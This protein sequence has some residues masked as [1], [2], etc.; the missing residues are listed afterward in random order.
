MAVQVHVLPG[1]DVVVRVGLGALVVPRAVADAVGVDRLTGAL[2]GLEGSRFTTAAAQV[3]GADGRVAAVSPGES[4]W[5]VVAPEGWQVRTRYADRRSVNDGPVHAV[6]HDPSA[7]A[8][9]GPGVDLLDGWAVEEGA[10]GLPALGEGDHTAGGGL[11]LVVVAEPVDED[12]VLVRGIRCDCGA[13]HPP[14]TLACASCG[15]DL[16]DGPLVQGVRPSL[17]ELHVDDGRTFPLTS[18]YVLGREPWDSH[19]VTEGMARPL[20]LVDASRLV[21]R[22]H[23]TLVLDGWDVVVT[24]HSTGGTSVR[25][26]DGHRWTVLDAGEPRV[27]L[28]GS[29]LRLGRRRVAF[30]AAE[31]RR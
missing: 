5:G 24:G 1:D 27:L 28:P 29:Q 3:P 2:A 30:T 10:Q 19:A 25:P 15:R 22:V 26:P 18:T 12:G 14:L 13:L 11:V 21:S 23:A 8:L 16:P 17:G 20:E 31:V 4:G 9:V 7:L 6:K